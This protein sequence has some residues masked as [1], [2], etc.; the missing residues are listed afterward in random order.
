MFNLK[1]FSSPNCVTIR[2]PAWTPQMDWEG[3]SYR[4]MQNSKAPFHFV[5]WPS[6]PSLPPLKIPLSTPRESVSQCTQ[7]PPAGIQQQQLCR[8]RH[9]AW[10]LVV[11]RTKECGW[12]TTP[13]HKHSTIC[14]NGSFFYT[15]RWLPV[16][17]LH[18]HH[19][20]A[21]NPYQNLAHQ[22]QQQQKKFI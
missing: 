6:P 13:W 4:F 9:T 16:L 1:T 19:T 15:L 17:K 5:L 7:S 18:N 3:Q 12:F 2:T 21:T 11:S 20:N 14:S 22:Q 8:G 10:D